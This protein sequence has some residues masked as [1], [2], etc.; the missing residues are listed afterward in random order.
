MA[1]TPVNKL[2][3]NVLNFQYNPAGI[4]RA[5][6][7]T[8]TDV[9]DGKI[10]VVDPTNP[11]VFLM[12]SSAVMTSAAMMKA[13]SC[14]RKQYP[15]AAQTPED[16]YIHM[17]DKDYVDRFAVPAT[18]TISLL[19]L[20]NEVLNAL[21]TDPDTGMKK[22]VIPRNTY[23]TVADTVFSLQYPIEIRQPLHEGLQVVYDV[24]VP[25]PLQTLE[26]NVIELD[27][28]Q[29]QEGRWLHFSVQAQQFKVESQNGTLNAAQDFVV[30][31]ELEDQYY[32]TRV[33]AEDGN[34]NWEEIPTTH[35]D[36]I[37]DITEP[38][39]VLKVLD[40]TVQLRIPQIYTSTKLLNRAIRMDFYQTKGPVN[41]PLYEYPIGSIE[42]TWEAYDKNDVN[43]FVAPMKTLRSVL[44]YSEEAVTGGR[45]A[46]TF[47]ELR[48]RVI[49]NAIGSPSLPIT[50]TQIES[51]LE[52]QGYAVVKNIDN[53]TNRVFQATKEMPTPSDTRLITAAAASIETMSVSI[54]DIVHIDTVIDNGSSVTVTPDTLY[55]TIDGIT[56]LVN[57]EQRNYLLNLPVDKRALI[58]TSGGYLYT[59]FHY[60]LDMSGNEFDVR[61]YYLDDPTI[62]TKVFVAENDTTLIQAGTQSYGI[63]RVGN[64]YQITVVTQ[65][66]DAFKD[67]ED[68]DVYAQLAYVPA[69]EKDRAFL[70][71]VLTGKTDDG[72][73]IYTFD[74]STN[75][76]VDAKDN[77]QLSKFFLYTTEARL[78]G[79]ALETVF[80]VVYSTSAFMGPQWK[81]N[82]VDQ[83]LGRFLL[84]SRIA[85]IAHEQLKVRFGYSLD[86]LWARARSVISSVGYKTYDVDVPRLYEKDVY[87]MDENGSTISFDAEGNPVQTL[88][89]KK[90][91]PVLDS[92]GDPV[93]Q[94]RKG[95]IMLDALSGDP[96]I[97]DVRGMIRQIDVMLIEGAYWFATDATAVKYRSDLTRTVVSWLTQD[98]ASLENQLLERTNI[99][100]YPKTTLGAIKVMVQD[101][102]VKTIPAG[103]AFRVDLYVSPQVYA[104]LALR[105]RLSK[106]TVKTI[107]DQLK[108]T[109]VSIDAIQ[110][111]LRA[112]YG[113]DVIANQ[114]TGLGG[115]LELPA[116][117]VVDESDRCSIRKRLVAQADDSLIVEEDVTINFIRHTR[118]V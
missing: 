50:P 113:T 6:L 25:S 16:L 47:E 18:A 71:G 34:G 107:S 54:K 1:D 15:M 83:V 88:L 23:F 63:E 49:K 29:S 74:L 90:G 19:L 81:P 35:T 64:G 85:G 41:L 94:Y 116:L 26:T 62:E 87:Q 46:L 14:T 78:T 67:L 97:S 10:D 91:D 36:Q 99:Y 80:D 43:M 82:Q 111:A 32:Y 9:T 110:T 100:F 58:V 104:N 96:I 11:F 42:A 37:Y 52:R 86:T 106:T 2:L 48:A 60:V 22:L 44:V 69:G 27:Y 45:D 3:A 101:G 112:Q 115:A 114:V 7:Q 8:L 93:Y 28:R 92:N 70:N 105:E 118:T 21:V 13:E 75:F 66:G 103:Q 53:I 20:E 55:Q 73:R 30:T 72:E 95:D 79:A 24:S 68:D 84:P 5:A 117:T 108:N 33:Y 39:A 51:T 59:P 38:T 77:L 61:P 17:S 31:V 65:S 76:N 56:S 109:T 4:Q 89:H 12:E 102:L 57:N 98:L 40:N